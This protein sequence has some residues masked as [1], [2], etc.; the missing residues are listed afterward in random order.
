[1]LLDWLAPVYDRY[2][3]A[4][5]LGSHFRE[6]TLQHAGLEPGDRVLDVGCGTGVLTRVARRAV[7]PQGVVVGID[8]G[9]VMIAR[10]RENARAGADPV[11]FRLAAIEKLPFPDASFDVVLSSLMFHH[12]P[13]ATK[14]EGLREVLR[15]LVPGG[16]LVLVDV[17]R[18]A[19]L[20]W[21]LV[22]WPF[23]FLPM[24]AG[25]LRGEVPAFVE[26]AGFAQGRATGRWWGLL[27]FW[28][29][30]KPT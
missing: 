27:S 4:I 17:D 30:V 20:L 2:C 23:L 26:S 24:T 9:P 8:P 16:K 10:A 15:V 28:R 11:E 13:P 25:N 7:G 18:P 3:S 29:A 21:W 12:L 6:V 19:N 14:G 1:M 5:G 22:A